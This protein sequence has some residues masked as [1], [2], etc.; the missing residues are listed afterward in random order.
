M[1]KLTGKLNHLVMT[2]QKP[3]DTEA[4][5]F[6]AALLVF[7]RKG[8]AATRMQEIA[9]HAGINKALLHYY[10]RSKEKLYQQVFARIFQEHFQKLGNL[11]NEED[12]FRQVLEK[13]IN[14]YM[15]II[16][17]NPEIPHFLLRE[18]ADGGARVM[19]VLENML[20]H[21]PKMIPIHLFIEQHRKAVKRGEI[22]NSDPLQLFL[23]VMGASLFY[24]I[25]RPILGVV[26]PVDT[27]R[28]EDRFLKQRKREILDT[29]YS[30]I[31]KGEKDV[32]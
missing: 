25:T 4:I 29:I 22:R 28:K 7:S 30:G 23:T 18:S 16:R 32:V 13:L 2:Q 19:Q 17:R 20:G 11:V 9:D 24:F 14:R 3:P 21:D 6:R 10:F 27:K 5:I 31:R 1:V 26:L 12:T 15:D 8:F